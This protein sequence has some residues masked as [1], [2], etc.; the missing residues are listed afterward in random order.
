LIVSTEFDVE[1]S[2]LA[3]TPRYSSSVRIVTLCRDVAEML[4]DVG[5]QKSVITPC[6]ERVKDLKRGPDPFSDAT[7]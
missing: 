7:I 2:R 6:L 4:T 5:H 3:V 1:H